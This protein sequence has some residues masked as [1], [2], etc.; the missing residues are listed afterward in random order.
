MFQKKF[1]SLVSVVI[2]GAENDIAFLLSIAFQCSNNVAA[3]PGDIIS[4]P[5]VRMRNTRILTA[6]P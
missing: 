5:G 6:A 1:E 4:E 3:L 2:H